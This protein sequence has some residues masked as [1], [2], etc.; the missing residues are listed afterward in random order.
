MCA[1]LRWVELSCVVCLGAV[2]ELWFDF[3]ILLRS[4][5]FKEFLL[6]VS[7]LPLLERAWPWSRV[8]AKDTRNS[9]SISFS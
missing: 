9:R 8:L 5:C 6:L 4:F 1:S 3:L 2:L 7:F